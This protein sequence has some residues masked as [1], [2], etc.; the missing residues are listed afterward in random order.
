M[1]GLRPKQLVRVANISRELPEVVQVPLKVSR[2]KSAA[3]LQEAGCDVI[4][5]IVEDGPLRRIRAPL[6][7]RM[8]AFLFNEKTKVP[9]YFCSFAIQLMLQLLV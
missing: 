6:K 9:F 4:N 2:Q 1:H 5:N 7:I 3:K 8:L